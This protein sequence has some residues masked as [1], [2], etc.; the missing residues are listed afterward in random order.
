MTSCS[1]NHELL[2][3]SV[4]SVFDW[5]STDARKMLIKLMLDNDF[6]PDNGTLK[7][8]QDTGDAEIVDMLLN[9]HNNA[10]E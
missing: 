9:Y 3:T 5:K 6:E 8:A 10:Q 4:Q 7:L 1:S 2:T